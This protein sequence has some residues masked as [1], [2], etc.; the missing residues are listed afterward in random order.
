MSRHSRGTIG[1]HWIVALTILTLISMG[2]AI[3]FADMRWLVS[4][5]KSIGVLALFVIL[6]RVIWRI[7]EGWPTPVSTH[8]EREIAIARIVHWA[9]LIATLGMPISGI[10]LSGPSGYGIAVFGFEIIPRNPDPANPDAV[11]ALWPALY[12]FGQW[13]H[14]WL[15]Y[16]LTGAIIFHIAGALK[17]HCFD[18]DN[19]LR[20]M[21]GIKADHR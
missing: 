13:L 9:L 17:H 19:T 14:E 18:R 7:R 3:S 1:F 6:A 10:M 21:V 20:S 11:I 2:Y 8:Q 5:H 15:S 16:L 4:W 12:K